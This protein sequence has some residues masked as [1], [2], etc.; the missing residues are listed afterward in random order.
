[1]LRPETGDSGFEA[2]GVGCSGR[3]SQGMVGTESLSPTGFTEGEMTFDPGPRVSGLGDSQQQG[4]LLDVQQEPLA[5]PDEQADA[6]P[7]NDNSPAIAAR[8][9]QGSRSWLRRLVIG[10]PPK[11]S[12]ACHIQ[13]YIRLAHP[14]NR[15]YRPCRV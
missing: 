4:A 13:D 6:S 5:C 15:E 7:T 8:A 2:G 9:I 12:P 11:S 10:I 14:D 1:M 3:H